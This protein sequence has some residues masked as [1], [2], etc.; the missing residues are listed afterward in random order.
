MSTMY[1]L[2][3]RD[4]NT[5]LFIITML[6]MEEIHVY[7]IYKTENGSRQLARRDNLAKA[8]ERE[9]SISRDFARES[10]CFGTNPSIFPNV[11]RGNGK[12]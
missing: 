1:N 11:S 6:P 9:K 2:C 4:F 7:Q 5:I 10:F 8:M 12:R 3:P